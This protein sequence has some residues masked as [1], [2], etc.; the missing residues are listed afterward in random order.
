VYIRWV[1]RPNFVNVETH[2]RPR[3]FETV[4]R[5]SKLAT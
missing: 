4:A 5:V 1:L 3:H 2:T